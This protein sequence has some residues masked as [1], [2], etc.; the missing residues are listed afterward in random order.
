MAIFESLLK[1]PLFEPEPGLMIWTVISFALLLAVLWKVG[2]KPLADIIKKREDSIRG[3][4][5]EAER[6]RVDAEKLL[7][8]YKQQ[9]AEARKESHEII[10]QGKK[11]A[12]NVKT[13]ITR[14]RSSSG[15][16][17]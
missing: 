17:D 13:D 11:I 5:D 2:Y 10:E 3:S 12:E 8:N 1:I 4:I 14:P 15:V 7:E 16:T 6:V 9:L